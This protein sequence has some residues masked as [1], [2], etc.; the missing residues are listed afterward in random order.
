MENV[1][2][3]GHDREPSSGIGGGS[4]VSG[5]TIAVVLAVIFLAI[6]GPAQ[7]GKLS[8]LDDVVR[9]VI[10]EA[11]AGG[12]SVVKGGQGA[13]V[14]L[15]SA[16]RLFVQHDAE[17][18]LEQLVRRSDE[19]ARAGRRIE[20]LPRPCSRA[21][22]HAFWAAIPR[23]CVRSRRSSRRKSGWWSKWEKRL[24]GSRCVIPRRPRPWSAGWAQRG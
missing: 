2:R 12:K 20:A 5:M 24:A 4:A 18:G 13:R 8:W 7:A 11:R 15:R 9:E 10:A 1:S 17:E 22:L 21:G 23:P 19:L 16:G 14:E 6:P 3:T